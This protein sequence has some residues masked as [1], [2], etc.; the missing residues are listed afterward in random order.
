M[1][2]LVEIRSVDTGYDDIVILKNINLTIW[3]NDFD[4]RNKK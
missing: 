2:K 3:E 4:R 1:R